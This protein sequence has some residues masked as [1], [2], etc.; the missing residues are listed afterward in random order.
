MSSDIVA[1]LGGKAKKASLELSNIESSKKN[2]ALEK[3]KKELEI[4]TKELINI[5][6]E[7]IE[8]A[9][10]MNLSNAMIDRLALNENRIEG[11]IKSLDDRIN[12]KDPIGLVLS[13]WD[14]PNGLKIK[15]M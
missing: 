4:N 14:R 15:T 5:N 10:S 1:E 11:M 3:L 12:L 8:N 6:K 7:D 13:E 2:L 9:N